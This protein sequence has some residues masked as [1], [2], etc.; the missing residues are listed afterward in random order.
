VNNGS[1]SLFRSFVFITAEPPTGAV[2]HFIDFVLS[3]EGRDILTAEGLV[4]TPQE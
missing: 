4:P 2:K 1:Y 3:G